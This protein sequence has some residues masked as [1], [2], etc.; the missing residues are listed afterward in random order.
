MQVTD[1]EGLGDALQA[2]EDYFPE[3]EPQQV[4]TDCAC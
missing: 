1:R 2:F 3:L 4:R